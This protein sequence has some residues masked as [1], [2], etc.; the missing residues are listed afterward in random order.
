[1]EMDDYLEKK[2][3]GVH[4]LACKWLFADRRHSILFNLKTHTCNYPLV[5]CRMLLYIALRYAHEL[6]LGLILTAD[7]KRVLSHFVYDP[8]NRLGD[9]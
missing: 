7:E 5:Q 2:F 8:A 9:F 1:M 3:P 4:T 6:D